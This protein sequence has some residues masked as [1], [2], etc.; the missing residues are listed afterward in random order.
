MTTVHKNA[1]FVILCSRRLKFLPEAPC[2]LQIKTQWLNYFFET[3]L[4]PFWPLCLKILTLPFYV[5]DGWDFYQRL[6][7]VPDKNTVVKF[8]FW[9]FFDH[10][11]TTAPENANFVI[12][13]SRRLIF[14]PEAPCGLQIKTQWL[15]SFF[16]TILTPFWPLFLKMLI[17]P[18]Y[19][20]WAQ[21]N[22]ASLEVVLSIAIAS[23]TRKT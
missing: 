21:L 20:S 3:I 15:N 7:V 22:S 1:N 18:F 11:L 12:L 4:T 5:V 19:P 16:E 6:L 17:L 23:F 10:F 8:F 2:G 9:N 13:G 14:L